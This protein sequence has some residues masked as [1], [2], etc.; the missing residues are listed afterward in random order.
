MRKVKERELV[1]FEKCNGKAPFQ[2]W[3]DNLKDE[4]MQNAVD[5]R[6]SRVADGNFGDHKSVGLGVFELRIDE[7]PGLRIY[8]GMDGDRIVVLLGGGSKASQK[9]DIK[10]CQTY[11]NEYLNAN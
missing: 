1:I 9:K 4:S 6:L 5:S 10:K 11:W 3:F 7:G 2:D 8:Y